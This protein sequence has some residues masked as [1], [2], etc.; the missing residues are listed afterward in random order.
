LLEKKKRSSSSFLPAPFRGNRF[1]QP[2]SGTKSSTVSSRQREIDRDGRGF[3][4][5][6][7]IFFKKSKEVFDGPIRQAG[8]AKHQDCLLPSLLG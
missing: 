2:F 5:S 3:F 6:T 1:F 7:E 4:K 8:H